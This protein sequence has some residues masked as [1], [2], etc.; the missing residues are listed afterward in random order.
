M[1]KTTKNGGKIE[2]KTTAQV[3]EWTTTGENPEA[4]R[5]IWRKKNKNIDK[6]D[7]FF[8]R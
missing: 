7:R 6:I 1:Q 8:F 4:N 3:N 2:E 5:K